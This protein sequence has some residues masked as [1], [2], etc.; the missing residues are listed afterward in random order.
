[1]PVV[2]GSPTA[3][4]MHLGSAMSNKLPSID[5]AELSTVTGGFLPKLPFGAKWFGK[6]KPFKIP[7]ADGPGHTAQRKPQG[8]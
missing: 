3:S 2:A 8:G 7:A 6:S 5:T 4:P 1:M